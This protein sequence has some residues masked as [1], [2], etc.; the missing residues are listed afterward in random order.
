MVWTLQDTIP[1]LQRTRDEQAQF[2]AG[3]E[4]LGLADLEM[5]KLARQRVVMLDDLVSRSA[6]QR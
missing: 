4:S 3:M 5:T 6:Q 2:V 1:N